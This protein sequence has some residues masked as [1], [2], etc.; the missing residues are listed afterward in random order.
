MTRLLK[1]LVMFSVSDIISLNVGRGINLKLNDKL[2]SAVG[3]NP[4]R[5]VDL[6]S[7]KENALVVL[8]Y[9]RL[10]LVHFCD[11]RDLPGFK[12]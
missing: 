6:A 5:R 1:L 11:E 8:F 10:K 2:M 4:R 3:L 9:V 12:H 7:E